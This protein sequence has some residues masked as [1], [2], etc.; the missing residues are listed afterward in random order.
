MVDRIEWKR[1]Y[2]LDLRGLK[3]LNQVLSVYGVPL[4]RRFLSAQFPDINEA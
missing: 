2:G 1:H 4:T 3:D